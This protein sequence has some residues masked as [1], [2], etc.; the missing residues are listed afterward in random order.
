[1]WRTLWICAALVTMSV[2]AA[3]LPAD[4]IIPWDPGPRGGI[5]SPTTIFCNVTNSIPGT[6]I[7]CVGNGT[8]DDYRA[9][10]A[11]ANLCPSNQVIYLPPGT[12]KLTNTVTVTKSG[13]VVR[14]AGTNLT[15][16]KYYGPTG[17]DG[18]S[19]GN[20]SGTIG[21]VN[22]TGGFT[23]GTTTITVS[24]TNGY[25]VGAIVVVATTNNIANG[26]DPNTWPLF[27]V[28]NTNNSGYADVY[29]GYK[30]G[31]YSLGH[32]ARITNATSTTLSID[33]PLPTDYTN[34]QNLVFKMS[35]FTERVGIE[36]LTI[37]DSATNA[38]AGNHLVFYE[39][40]NSWFSN[41][42]SVKVS[43]THVRFSK[44]LWCAGIDS[45]IDDG[46]AFTANAS[47]GL[48]L[49]LYSTA[50]LIQ[51]NVFQRC[52]NA[53]QLVTASQNVIAYNFTTNNV[54]PNDS[55]RMSFDFAANHGAHP[56][57]NLFEG[58]KGDK[59]FADAIHG[60]G[61][62]FVYLRNWFRAWGSNN[63]PGYSTGF[64]YAVV[65]ADWAWGNRFV[66]AVG[67]ILGTTNINTNTFGWAS[68][69]YMHTNPPTGPDFQDPAIYQVGYFNSAGISSSKDTNVLYTLLLYNNLVSYTNGPYQ[70]LNTESNATAMPDSY[71]LTNK[72]A[73]FGGWQWPPMDPLR[74]TN[75]IGIIPAEARYFALADPGAAASN[76]IDDDWLRTLKLFFFPVILPPGI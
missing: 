28:G 1:M 30:S 46:L 62:H 9:M 13:V 50:C 66:S 10:Q 15:F 44:C 20:N 45:W 57:M 14:G 60:T 51:N 70:I 16:T 74:S 76:G 4:R 59:T 38:Y 58:N 36:N 73:W 56:C 35:T 55:R 40:A 5:T 29:T 64:V 52:L 7:V 17:G 21:D 23:K 47:Y 75:R 39:C 61:S 18:W 25:P 32:L 49:Y 71:Y 68:F 2:E 69:D 53:V 37:I 27:A 48:E 6:N 65:A 63:T 26:S 19:F 43:A 31:R 11:A 41:I 8:T 67:N 34:G 42:F 72:P 22:W 24:S 3:I 54:G 12:Y 33:P